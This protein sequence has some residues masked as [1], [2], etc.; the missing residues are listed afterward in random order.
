RRN[1]IPFMTLVIVINVPFYTYLFL[2][3]YGW[4]IEL[5]QMLLNF[6]Y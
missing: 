4:G 1:P 5:K 6:I 2:T 3:I